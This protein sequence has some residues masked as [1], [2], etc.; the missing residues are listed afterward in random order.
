MKQAIHYLNC[1]LS[2]TLNVLC[3]PKIICACASITRLFV[4]ALLVPFI[5][6]KLCKIIHIQNASMAYLTYVCFTVCKHD[7]NEAKKKITSYYYFHF[8]L[9][10]FT[11]N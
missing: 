2:I 11:V 10:F 3:T 6:F 1:I 7:L 9:Y 8:N 5:V 4:S